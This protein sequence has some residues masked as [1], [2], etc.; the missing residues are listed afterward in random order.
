[1]DSQI[2]RLEL[3]QELM[4]SANNFALKEAKRCC[5]KHMR[6]DAI[7]SALL[8]LMTTPPRHDPAKGGAPETLIYMRIRWSIL[9]YMKLEEKRLEDNKRADRPILMGKMEAV[10]E[11]HRNEFRSE[12]FQTADLR[13]TNWTVDD[14]LEFIDDRESCAM[15]KSVIEN[16]G[17]VSK[18]AREL[19]IPPS[20]VRARVKA[21]APKL[22]TAGFNPYRAG[23]FDGD[24]DDK[25]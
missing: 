1:M 18:A 3:T 22:I 13:G 12:S 7:Q 15:C 11:N 4:E 25:G 5:P 9:N 23:V 21:L 6:D 20:T 14:M 24:D 16:N 8:Y 10:S 2:P 17:N 19:D